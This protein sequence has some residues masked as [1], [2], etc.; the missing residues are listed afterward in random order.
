MHIAHQLNTTCREW[1]LA[2]AEHLENQIARTQRGFR[3]TMNLLPEKFVLQ[4]GAWRA[5]LAAE[6]AWREVPA[7][8]HFLAINRVHRPDGEF[9]Q[10]PVMN[11]ENYVKA[12]PIGERCIGGQFLRRGVAIDE[13]S[14]S[15]GTPYD[16]V[17]GHAERARMQQTLARILEQMVD[18]KPRLAIN[19]FSMGAWSTGQNMAQALERHSTVKSTGPDIEK[20]LHTLEFF[21]P[22]LGYFLAGYPPFLKT[23]VDE[24]LKRNFPISKYELHGLVGGEAISE[25]LRRY[26]LHYLRTCHSGYGASDL[27]MGVAVETP[28]AVHIRQLLND[29]SQLREG[30]LGSGQRIPMVFQYNPMCHYLETNKEGDLIATLTYSKTLSPRIRYNIGD[31]ARLFTRS[32]L[33]KRM[34]QFGKNT[35]MRAGTIPLPLPYLLLFGRRDQTISIMGA[36]IYP[37]DVERALYL[38]QELA[39]GLTSFQLT[40]DGTN[41]NCIHPKLC[42]EWGAREIPGFSAE[43]LAQR[44]E[45]SLA[46]IN[47]D[48]RHARKESAM[49]M[50]LELAIFPVGTGPFAGKERRIKNRYVTRTV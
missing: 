5:R 47:S 13:S 36:N 35:E 17:R 19:A 29:D 42:I 43:R 7:Y 48:F 22:R 34:Q 12:Y 6:R 9:S 25:E 26:L 16:W 32:E 14:G 39:V 27:E 15:S 30:L 23:V 18:D 46:E 11:K 50:K 1:L 37:A 28:E 40:V 4:Q 44:V 49:N 2:G 38:Q 31:E 24:M 33:L 41:G 20:V 10:L 21:G 45:Q 8:Q 3:T